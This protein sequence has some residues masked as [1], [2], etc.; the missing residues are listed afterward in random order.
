VGWD[1]WFPSAMGNEVLRV[2]F[3]AIAQISE[4]SAAPVNPAVYIAEL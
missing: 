1:F 3:Q 2:F 4:K